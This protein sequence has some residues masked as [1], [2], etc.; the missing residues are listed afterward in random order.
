[1]CVCVGEDRED[2]MRAFE[3]SIYVQLELVV[4]AA[5]G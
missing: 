2:E 1:M 5:D 3:A 4:D